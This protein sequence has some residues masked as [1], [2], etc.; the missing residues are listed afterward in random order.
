LLATVAAAWSNQNM[1][2]ECTAISTV[3]FV[4]LTRGYIAIVDSSDLQVLSK[5]KWHAS[6]G[7][8][9]HVY[10]HDGYMNAMHRVVSGAKK[11]QFV[12]HANGFGLDNRKSNIRIASHKQNMRNRKKRTASTKSKY[13]G[14]WKRAEYT[15]AKSKTW[16]SCIRVDRKTI[17]LGYYATELEAAVAYDA[18]AIKH[19][20][21]FARLN[22]PSS[23]PRN[24]A[25]QPSGAL[26]TTAET[27][28]ATAYSEP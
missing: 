10:A 18:A 19:H 6:S 24:S 28:T 2:T 8:T 7:E 12:D 15:R 5:T 17:H 11:G 4:H 20:G 14:P 26:A 25:S 13:K 21:E 3:G 22:F 23:A 9:G 1:A 27:T 16:G